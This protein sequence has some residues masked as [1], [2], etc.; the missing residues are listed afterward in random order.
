MADSFR[1]P[2]VLV[3]G[4]SQGVGLALARILAAQDRYRLVLTARS[5]SLERL[6]EVGFSPGRDVWPLELDVADHKSRQHAVSLVEERWG[7]VDVLVNNAGLMMRA[8]LEHASEQD[9]LEQFAVNYRGPM[10]LIRLILPKMRERRS[11][12]IINVS[13]VGGMMA[14]PTMS[15]YS[16]SK[17]A[18]EGASEA[19]YYEVRPWNVFVSLVQPGFINSDAIER[20]IHTDRGIVEEVNEF[21][22]YHQHY[23]FMA[24]FIAKITHRT[25]ATPESVARRM[26]RLIEQKRPPLRVAGT[27]DALLFTILRRLLPRT[28][29]HEVLYRA[30]PGITQWGKARDALLRAPSEAPPARHPYSDNPVSAIVDRARILSSADRKAHGEAEREVPRDPTK[31]GS[32]SS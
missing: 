24:E 7:G 20:V 16:A 30:L 5:S 25:K 23:H 12:R 1:R 2:V 4:A 22:P 6:H 32:G 8:V 13:S 28:L 19:L 9:H 15:V 14:M 11:G 26:A 27:F 31:T 18:L 29:Y 21:S 10:E 3:T 17:F